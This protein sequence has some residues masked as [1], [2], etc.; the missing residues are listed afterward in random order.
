MA[1]DRKEA[2]GLVI[3]HLDAELVEETRDAIEAEALKN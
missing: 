2:D 3:V 1:G